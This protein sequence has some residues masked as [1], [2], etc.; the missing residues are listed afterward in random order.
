MV[1]SDI[2]L[3]H[4]ELMVLLVF[5]GSWPTL[6]TIRQHW[7][8]SIAPPRTCRYSCSV[9]PL[10]C[11]DRRRCGPRAPLTVAHCTWHELQRTF[12]AQSS[13][14]S[15]VRSR[16]D[17]RAET[18]VQAWLRMLV[19]S[20]WASGLFEGRVPELEA[21]AFSL[22]SCPIQSCE[23][24]LIHNQLKWRSCCCCWPCCPQFSVKPSQVLLNL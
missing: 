19:G 17:T 8:W 15:W 9:S 22:R 1:S 24:D 5:L 21:S 20:R 2:P 16:S 10:M 6:R 13:P 4:F 12:E 23:L 7:A 3:L 11:A 18:T 14:L